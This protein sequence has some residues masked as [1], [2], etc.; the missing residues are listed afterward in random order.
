MQEA[1]LQCCAS[2]YTI[3]LRLDFWGLIHY[4]EQTNSACWWMFHQLCSAFKQLM[5]C[6]QSQLE[7]CLCS[8][9]HRN[10]THITYVWIRPFNVI[11]VVHNKKSDAE[12]CGGVAVV[13]STAL[14]QS[15]HVQYIIWC[16]KLCGIVCQ[17]TFLSPLWVLQVS[18]SPTVWEEAKQI[19]AL[20]LLFT[21]VCPAHLVSRQSVACN[22]TS[23]LV[24]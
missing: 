22:V 24:P 4:S 14:A 8:D 11:C 6:K 10:G 9:C 19:G 15:E 23:N 5:I 7:P 3:T 1:S 2:W 21:H 12:H 17:S 20:G 18:C 13:R 16:V